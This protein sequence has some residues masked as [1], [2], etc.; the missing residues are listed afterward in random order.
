MLLATKLTT[1]V[2]NHSAKVGSFF[3]QKLPISKQQFLSAPVLKLF[4]ESIN[5]EDLEFME[6]KILKIEVKDWAHEQYFSVIDGSIQLVPSQSPDIVFS[7]T[8]ASFLALLT[9]SHDPDT[10]FFQ[11]HLTITGD[12]ELG[13]ELKAFFDYFEIEKLR[14]PIKQL[15]QWL[16]HQYA[17]ELTG[18]PNHA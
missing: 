6:N 9:H 10:L 2:I 15:L 11:R 7:G 4:S 3:A 18:H 16:S 17:T 13:L 1:Q 12:T 8:V 14:T 5:M